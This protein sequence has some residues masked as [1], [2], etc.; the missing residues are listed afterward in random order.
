MIKAGLA[1]AVMAF[2]LQGCAGA[3]V[4]GESRKVSREALAPTVAAAMPDIDT[5]AATDCIIK[6]M[7]VVEVLALPNST[8]GNQPEALSGMVQEV[9]TRPGV[10]TCLAAAPKVAG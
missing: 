8:S 3:L 1:I 9:T 4:Y 6:G 5:A 2:G 7:T 10:D